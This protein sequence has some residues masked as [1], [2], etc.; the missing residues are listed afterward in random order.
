MIFALCC[1]TT[2]I[3]VS[4]F[5]FL[6]SEEPPS[7][8]VVANDVDPK[9]AYHLVRRCAALGEACKHLLVTCHPGQKFPN[10]HCRGAAKGGASSDNLEGRYPPGIYDR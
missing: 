5:V 6:V 3:V 7:G 8:L 9:R 4:G 1:C 10:V 2:T